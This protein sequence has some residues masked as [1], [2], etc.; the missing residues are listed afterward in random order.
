[1]NESV[2]L[3]VSMK[4]MNPNHFNNKQKKKKHIKGTKHYSTVYMF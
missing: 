4:S 3:Y 2:E 1:M